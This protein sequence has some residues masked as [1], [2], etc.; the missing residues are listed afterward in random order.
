MLNPKEFCDLFNDLTPN[1]QMEVTALFD[2]FQKQ[3]AYRQQAFSALPSSTDIVDKTTLQ[4]Y[5]PRLE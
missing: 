4:G 1:Q 3:E 2:R 5:P